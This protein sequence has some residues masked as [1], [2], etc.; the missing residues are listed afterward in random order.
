MKT[1]K[2]SPK[3][4][5]ALVLGKRIPGTPPRSPEEVEAEAAQQEQDKFRA[6][7]AFMFL[8]DVAEDAAREHTRQVL[9]QSKP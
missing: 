2:Y 4:N 6:A 9:R 7:A 3:V 5:T 8:C 1:S